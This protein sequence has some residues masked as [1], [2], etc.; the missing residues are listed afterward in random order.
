MLTIKENIEFETIINKSRFICL[1]YKINDVKNVNSILDDIKLKY[2]DA[3]HYCFAYIVNNC[4]KFDDDGE[5]SNTA[6]KPILNVLEK[7][8]LNNVLCVVVRYFGGIK[9]GA[10]GLTRAYTKSVTNSLNKDN[11]IE[12]KEGYKIIITF[13]YT[14]N[15]VIDILLKDSKILNKEFND[16][17]T[18]E[19]IIDTE[20]YNEIYN[21]LNIGCLS[22]SIIDKVYI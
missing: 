10:G 22:L 16:I 2:K 5:P 8:K 7:N 6:G 3:T 20:A 21:A 12:L 13:D 19:F 11:I 14:K 4:I 9:L 1:L 17:I 15:K 18:Y